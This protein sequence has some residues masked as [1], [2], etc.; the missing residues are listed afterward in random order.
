M[1]FG[2]TFLIERIEDFNK[3]LNIVKDN[4]LL[5]DVS[6]E[7]IDA[8]IQGFDSGAC[9][10]R[11]KELSDAQMA[12][13]DRVRR[14]DFEISDSYSDRVKDLIETDPNRAIGYKPWRKSDKW[15]ITGYF[16]LNSRIVLI[17]YTDG[18]FDEG[19]AILSVTVSRGELPAVTRLW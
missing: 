10:K 6:I 11:S 17:S 9:W 7:P 4:S 8:A 14:I 15:L 5:D 19:E 1:P 2:C 12:V 16:F 13:V 18:H 3:L